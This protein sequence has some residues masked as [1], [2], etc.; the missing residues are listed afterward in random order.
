MFLGGLILVFIGS[1]SGP[2]SACINAVAKDKVYGI[3]G[4]WERFLNAL[5]EHIA[6]VIRL[7]AQQQKQYTKMLQAQGKRQSP[8]MFLAQQAALVLI[9]FAVGLLLAFRSPVMPVLFGACGGI[10]F[11]NSVQK[12]K[13]QYAQYQTEVEMDLPKLCSVINSRLSSTK[14]VQSIL[15]SFLPIASPAMREEI[16]LTLND[17]KTGSQE[18][19]LLRMESRL[20]SPKVSDVVRGLISVLN[21]DNQEAYF[22][23]KQG[24][25]N[26]DY[27]TV[28]R[29]EIAQRPMKLMIPETM[30]FLFFFIMILYP[31]GASIMSSMLGAF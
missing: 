14:N 4:R 31:I 18:I 10:F 7:T 2:S 3:L 9:L 22:Q 20:G 26:N 5:A 19:A 25:F 29:K 27:L 8:E 1:F 13:K 28:R 12:L 24:Q 30:A 11:F 23:S 21:G 16:K 17:M 6:P 15:T